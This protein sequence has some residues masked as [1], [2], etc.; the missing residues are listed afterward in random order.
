MRTL[1]R[2]SLAFALFI[3]IVIN[4]SLSFYMHQLFNFGNGSNLFMPV[5]MMLIALFDETNKKELWLA[6]GT[7]IVSDIFFFGIIGIYAVI[8]PV[9][10][11]IMQETARFLP[12]IFWA[13]ILAVLIGSI[14]VNG[15]TWLALNITG[16][17]SIPITKLLISLFPTIVWSFVFTAITYRLWGHLALNHPFMVKLDNYRH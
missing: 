12:E 16:I 5:G 17:A 7:G 10:V 8:L 15:Y 11:W 6:L 2:Y 13:R 14:L 3:A 9:L 4:G 1:Q